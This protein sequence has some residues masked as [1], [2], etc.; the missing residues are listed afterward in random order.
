MKLFPVLLAGG[1]GTRLWP[2]SREDFPKQFLKL[3]DEKFSLLQL[4]ARR[5]AALPNV[6]S[7]IVVTNEKYR[8][9]VYRQLEEV[10]VKE[11]HILLETL[12]KNTAPAI[13]LAAYFISD[14]LKE[15][16]KESVML[17]MP[18]DHHINDTNKLHKTISAGVNHSLNGEIGTFGI[19]PTLPITGYGYIRASSI[20]QGIGRVEEFVEKPSLTK[21]R[22]YLRNG[23]YYWNSGIF[24]FTVASYLDKLTRFAPSIKKRSNDAIQKMTKDMGFFRPDAKSFSRCPQDS[25]DYAIME[26]QDDAFLVPLKAQWS[27]IGSWESLAR[28]HKQDRRS[29]VAQGHCL[30]HDTKDSMVY[31]DKKLVTT[32]GVDS[33]IIA[34]TADALLVAHKSKAEEVKQLVERLRSEKYPEADAQYR[35]YRPWGWFESLIQGD[36]FQVKRLGVYP[37]AALSLQAHKYR[38]EHW[39]VVNG[40]A[41][42]TNGDKQYILQKNQSTYVPRGNKH[43]LENVDNDFLEIIEVQSGSYLGEDDIKRYEDQYGRS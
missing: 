43:K 42:V 11:S 8:F 24:V 37:H 36:G 27:D 38:A 31:A 12:G 3:T 4:A 6:E 16:P 33:L 14:K 35:N 18:S 1:T 17:V 41:R 20:Q 2:M 13:A 40:V 15:D 21:A 34:D 32:L 26:K 28:T 25:I 29:N 10:G 30:L 23:N 7:I 22:Q 5:A 39:V 9:L 19:K